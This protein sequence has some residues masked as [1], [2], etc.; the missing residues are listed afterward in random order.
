[1]P[2]RQFYR[3]ILWYHLMEPFYGMCVPDF[4]PRRNVN[5]NP[6]I[7]ILPDIGEAL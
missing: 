3:A 2:D 6:P 1:M 4:R 5:K 7:T